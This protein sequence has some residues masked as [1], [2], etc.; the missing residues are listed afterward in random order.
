MDILAKKIRIARGRKGL[1]QAEL[2]AL[3]G[4]TGSAVGNW[5]RAVTRVDDAHLEMLRQI[6]DIGS[7][8]DEDIAH[9][10]R[11]PHRVTKFSIDSGALAFIGGR[12]RAMTREKGPAY[13]SPPRQIHRREVEASLFGIN[14]IRFETVQALADFIVGS[15]SGKQ[16]EQV[17]LFDDMDDFYPPDDA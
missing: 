15:E 14:L 8:T 11:K 5:E 4:V 10:D 12:H 13:G 1:K 7:I 2:G 6:L 3:I 16:L 17:S 9:A